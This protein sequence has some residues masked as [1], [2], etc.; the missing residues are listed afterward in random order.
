MSNIVKDKKKSLRDRISALVATGRCTAEYAEKR[1]FPRLD[2]LVMSPDQLAG[3]GGDYSKLRD[4][5]EDLIEG[6]EQAQ[7]LAGSSVVD[8]G[9]YAF[10]RPPGTN[11]E[12]HPEQN[13]GGPDIPEKDQDEMI[14]AALQT[15]GM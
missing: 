15:V 1:L 8:D 11:L 6:L 4:P 3:V 9:D 13:P 2:G 10:D 7:P 12:E 5:V 14:A